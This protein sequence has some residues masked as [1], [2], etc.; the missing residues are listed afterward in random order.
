MKHIAKSVLALMVSLTLIGPA[1]AAVHYGQKIGD[2]VVDNRPCLIFSLKGGP[3]ADPTISQDRYFA[4]AK[5]NPA[6]SEWFAIL[7][8]AKVSDLPLD[9][10]TDG[11]TVCGKA[12]IGQIFMPQV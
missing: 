6:F 1:N 2:L 7:M 11:T 5:S 4:I 9:V 8:T 10:Y 3:A 12:A